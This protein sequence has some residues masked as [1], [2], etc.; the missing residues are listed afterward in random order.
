MF[1]PLFA[2]L[3]AST[4]V[5][6]ALGTPLRVY[7]FGESEQ[8]GTKP[9]A[10]WQTVGGEPANCLAGTPDTDRFAVQIDVY[11]KGMD[12]VRA[13]ALAIRDAIEP[14]AYITAYNGEFREPDTRLYRYS[15]TVEFLTQR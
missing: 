5:K 7:A 15:F 4:A 11:G 13:A 12:A 8:E 6:A 1:P 14:V 9:Y 2:T 3:N 10:V